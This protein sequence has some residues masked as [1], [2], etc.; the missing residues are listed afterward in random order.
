MATEFGGIAGVC[1]ADE[2]TAAFIAKRKNPAHKNSALYFK[3]DPDAQY[4]E[5]HII[6]L[7]KIEPLV[8]LYPS[9][10]NV[11]KAKQIEGKKLDGVFIGACTTAE[12]DLILAAMVLEQG[13][14]KGL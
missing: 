4:A 5:T 3:A 11:V 10:D 6:D 7:S 8:A 14:K 9:P 12:E 13:L 2:I 1:K